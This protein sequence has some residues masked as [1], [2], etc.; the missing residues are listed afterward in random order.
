MSI[1]ESC[2]RVA[3]AARVEPE[4]A[5]AAGV[6]FNEVAAADLMTRLKVAQKGAPVAAA[7]RTRVTEQW[8]EAIRASW[9][10]V[11]PRPAVPW[12]C[13]IVD[14]GE[15]AKGPRLICSLE[16][17]VRTEGGEAQWMLR[18]GPDISV[19][20]DGF[21]DGWEEVMRQEIGLVD[22]E[23]EAGMPVLAATGGSI[24]LAA[25]GGLGLSPAMQM[26][27]R[28]RLML[29]AKAE[30][31]RGLANAY[32]EE[33]GK[34]R[35]GTHVNLTIQADNVHE[36]CMWCAR[37]AATH[38]IAGDAS[39]ARDGTCSRGSLR[40]DGLIIAGILIEVDCDDNYLAELAAILD[41]LAA[42][43]KGSRVVVML[44]ATSPVH[45]LVKMRASHA[46]RRASYYGSTWLD[47]LDQLMDE[48]EVVVFLWQTSLM[49]GLP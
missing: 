10:G 14:V 21:V 49:S 16:E 35:E 24:T 9:S 8:K 43:P 12:Q 22:F 23:D 32:R 5:R 44:D 7:R 39:R 11:V 37:V 3:K 40:H 15:R 1:A 27:Y 30:V 4:E 17:G 26:L 28:A 19:G 13:G 48:L 45:A 25:L 33:H 42:V 47:T 18:R 31:V 6:V 38:V 2:E 41:Q 36:V 20:S 34:R 29:P 46:R